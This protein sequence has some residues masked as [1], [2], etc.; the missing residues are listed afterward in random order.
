[1]RNVEQRNL[2][3]D[4]TRNLPRMEDMLVGGVHSFFYAISIQATKHPRT[5]STSFGR[6]VPYML[7]NKT[8]LLSLFFVRKNDSGMTNSFNLT[9]NERQLSPT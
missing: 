7:S 2:T 8:E 3:V 9:K 1:M 5:P 4:S 6:D